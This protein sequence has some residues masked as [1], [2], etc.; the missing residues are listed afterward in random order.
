MLLLTIGLIVVLAIPP[1]FSFTTPDRSSR[2][3]GE[4]F[5]DPQPPTTE[6]PG[7]K[8]GEGEESGQ[9]PPTVG[10]RK[11]T[12]QEINRIRYMELR[13]MRLKTDRPDRVTV[14]I[15]SSVVEDFL[16]EMESHP[17]FRTEQSRREFHKLTA[18][19]KLHQIAF[20]KG[21]KYADRVEITSDPEAFVTFKKNVLPVTIRACGKAGCHSSTSTDERL[22]FRLFNDP[23][24]SA[25]TTYADFIM[26]SSAKTATGRV[27][28]RAYPEKSLLLTYMLP[29]QD[30]EPELRHPG[31]IVLTPV[32]RSANARGYRQILRW[33]STLKH[34]AEDYGVSFFPG[35]ETPTSGPDE[36]DNPPASTGTTTDERRPE[37]TAKPVPPLP[38]P[39]RPVKPL[40]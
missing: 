20:Y 33:I 6:P 22:R 15:P 28:D 34:P 35:S 30:V 24:R 29:D 19:Q 17:D 23:K 3:S 7:E 5:A 39:A 13:G 40:P 9:K 12:P 8:P 4:A 38:T 32:F 10:L 31:N 26:L 37:T 21:A 27:I 16:R 1:M 25:S 14:K 18:P 36:P 11:L 2:G